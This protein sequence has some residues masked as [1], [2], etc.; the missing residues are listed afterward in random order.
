MKRAY[1]LALIVSISAACLAQGCNKP[2]KIV[3]TK[4]QQR[5]IDE[6]VLREAPAPKT[7][8]NMIFGN[9]VKLL[10]MDGPTTAMKPG[11]KVTLTS[12]WE[13]LEAPKKNWKIFGHLEGSGKRQLLD[14]HPVRNLYPVKNWKKGEIIVDKQTFTLDKDFK[15]SEASLWIGFF[16]EQ[17]WSS[18]KENVRLPITDKGSATVG[19]GDR[20]KVFTIA[21]KASQKKDQKESP[22]APAGLYTVAP[23]HEAIV[24]DGKLDEKAW[25]STAPTRNFFRTDGEK[26]NGTL[27][28][29]AKIMADDT[30][31]YFGFHAKDGDIASPYTQRDETLWKAD[32]MEIFLD[33][34]QG[35]KSYV[36]IQVN[37]N[38]AVFDALFTSPRKPKWED[39]AKNLTL[40][41]ESAVFLDGTVNQSDDK[42]K[43]WSVEIRIPFAELPGLQGKPGPTD[44]WRMNLYRIDNKGPRNMRY[45]R[46]WSPVGGDFHKLDGAGQLSFASPVKATITP[47]T[48]QKEKGSAPP[49][50]SPQPGEK[51]K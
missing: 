13:V 3:L 24:I 8:L 7:A 46:T 33:T 28:T 18:R 29:H 22:K 41:I 36:E 34:G 16:D 38:N 5:E 31:L 25:R 49:A 32:V 43:S 17:A 27:A 40:G 42:D 47:K 44:V 37:P 6:H 45:Q 50:K 39:A 1:L 2:K 30:H 51:T 23:L 21:L 14:H 26:G 11:Q 20:A 10:G 48:P 35:D 19:K 4:E 12:Y 9:E 15:G